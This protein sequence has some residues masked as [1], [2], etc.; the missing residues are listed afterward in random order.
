M[1]EEHVRADAEADALL[2]DLWSTPV[3]R[4][5]VLKAGLGAAAAAALDRVWSHPA[6]AQ[7]AKPHTGSP[8]ST[9]LHFA[10]G[11]AKGVSGLELLAHGKRHRLVR[12]T[13]KSRAALR[14]K[15]G[16][17]GRIDLS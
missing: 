10:L 2:R 15:G 9:S 13:T 14:A 16:V 3:G 11:S 4:R 5:W 17:W 6:V 12:H 1:S 7:A 8:P